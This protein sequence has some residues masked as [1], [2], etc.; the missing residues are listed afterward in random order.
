MSELLIIL[1]WTLPFL[2]L[3]IWSCIKAR[4]LERKLEKEIKENN[5]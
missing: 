5:K 2:F 1:F 3:G 4:R